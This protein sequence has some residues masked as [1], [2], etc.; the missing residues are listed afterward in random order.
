M[1]YSIKKYLLA[2]SRFCG[3]IA[4][5]ATALLSGSNESQ[6]NK[7]DLVKTRVAIQRLQKLGDLFTGSDFFKK[8]SEQK[9]SI[10]S[11]TTTQ[12]FLKDSLSKIFSSSDK[13]DE[14][15]QNA[16]RTISLSFGFFTTPPKSENVLT[17][18]LKDHGFNQQSDIVLN[19]I[20]A[21]DQLGLK[22]IDDYKEILGNTLINMKNLVVTLSNYKQILDAFTYLD[23]DRVIPSE[24]P[25]VDRF[26]SKYKAFAIK[27]EITEFILPYIDTFFKSFQDFEKKNTDSMLTQLLL[28]KSYSPATNALRI[29]H[30]HLIFFSTD[31]L[32]KIKNYLQSLK[33]DALITFVEALDFLIVEKIDKKADVLEQTIVEKIKKEGVT[34]ETC[35]E[36]L[37]TL[38][39][40]SKKTTGTLKHTLSLNELSPQVLPL[41]EKNPNCTFR[42]DPE[43]EIH[44]LGK[45]RFMGA[46]FINSGKDIWLMGSDLHFNT[47]PVDSK[48]IQPIKKE[49]LAIYGQ[50]VISPDGNIMTWLDIDPKHHVPN[51]TL[52]YKLL[53]GNQSVKDKEFTRFIETYI[54]SQDSK[55]LFISFLPS[56]YYTGEKIYGLMSKIDAYPPRKVIFWFSDPELNPDPTIQLKRAH[57]TTV[58]SITCSPDGTFVVSTAENDPIAKVWDTQTGKLLKWLN[59]YTPALSVAISKDSTLIAMGGENGIIYILD[60]KNNKLFGTLK[61]NS[62]VCGLDWSPDGKIL[63][64]RTK[65]TTNDISLWSV[66]KKVCLAT[67]NYHPPEEKVDKVFRPKA[68][69]SPD[70]NFILVGNAHE[71]TLWPSNP[72]VTAVDWLKT[73][74]KTFE[75][76]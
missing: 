8:L 72:Q 74:Y 35:S 25:F 19:L 70:G 20:G 9:K 10:S 71:I 33:L 43:A 68:I 67:L 5:M 66:E 30:T 26:K 63:L 48:G 53:K 29:L 61:T 39:L 55:S 31:D 65:E 3:H 47:F 16:L 24:K 11:E 12:T 15:L 23:K 34:E 50:F 27:E 1:L 64:V 59:L 41:T 54:F 17:E 6:E 14:S 75:P 38:E 56:S 2:S 73:T 51:L 44:F 40:L 18:Y 42:S 36:L 69:F 57:A 46:D 7:K 49:V 60:N 76:V 13:K 37:T 4:L 22:N 32:D 21:M 62:P 58:T 52:M 28:K 45:S